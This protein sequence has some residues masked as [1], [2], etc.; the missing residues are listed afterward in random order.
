MAWGVGVPHRVDPCGWLA[1]E[2]ELEMEIEEGIGIRLRT[3]TERYGDRDR[4]RERETDRGIGG[5]PIE[6]PLKQLPPQPAKPQAQRPPHL[7]GRQAAGHV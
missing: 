5:P 1:D 6:E 7:Q 2:I 3:E 4:E